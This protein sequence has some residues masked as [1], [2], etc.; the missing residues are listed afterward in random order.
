MP[1]RLVDIA[2][3]QWPLLM[4]LYNVGCPMV[5]PRTLKHDPRLVQLVAAAGDASLFRDTGV[6]YFTLRN[7]VQLGK[8]DMSAYSL[9]DKRETDLMI[10]NLI[11]SAELRAVKALLELVL[12]TMRVFGLSIDWKRLPTALAKTK[13]LV[14]IEKARKYVQLKDCLAT[15]S[16]SP[17]RFHSWIRRQK[18]CRLDDY[19]TC[20]KTQPTKLIPEETKTI[21]SMV[22]SSEYSHFSIR[23]LALYAA[24]MG[25]V[26]CSPSTWYRTIK[27]LDLKR[28]RS[29][30]YQK[31]G[32]IGIRKNGPNELYHVDVTIIR[33]LNNTRIYIQLLLDNFSRYVIAWSVKSYQSGES[34]TALLREGAL[35]SRELGVFW[36]C[37][38]IYSDGGSENDNELVD[39]LISKGYLTRTIALSESTFSNSIPEALNRSLKHNCLFHHPL[40][41]LADVKRLVAFYID[42]HN[43]IM[44]HSAFNGATPLQMYTGTWTQKNEQELKQRF[45]DAKKERRQARFSLSCSNCP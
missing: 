24:I 41:T 36:N 2:I 44:P 8:G 45:V 31:D 20:P 11:I 39:R 13:I 34:T 22:K 27:V 19:S 35:H 26:V 30:V 33:L 15:I 7:W 16:L 1:T 9:L 38:E 25:F 40:N 4:N 18:E 28:Q 37:P 12:T 3:G 32:K 21:E 29:R 17:S 42:Q 10:K 43:N 5:F 14:A 6:S 23:A